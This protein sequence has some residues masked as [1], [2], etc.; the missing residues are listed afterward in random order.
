VLWLHTQSTTININFPSIYD[1]FL[2]KTDRDCINNSNLGN[3]Q[4][5]LFEA[6][7]ILDL[8]DETVSKKNNF[9]QMIHQNVIW[10]LQQTENGDFV[11]RKS[12]ELDDVCIRVDINFEKGQVIKNP[13]PDDQRVN[14]LLA[15]LDL[16]LY[17]NW[18]GKYG[19]LILHASGVVVNGVGYCFL[20]AS[21]A[22]KSTLA[23]Y[24]AQKH[25]LT[26]LGE[27]HII[28]R[29]LEGN[30]WVFG[31]PW[32]EDPTLC[33]PLGVPL[34]KLVFIDLEAKPGI[35]TINRLEGVTRVLQTAFVPYYRAD[36]T[37][38]ILE[39]LT[40]LVGDVPCFTLNYTLGSDPFDIIVKA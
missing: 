5:N 18:L 33:A 23:A 16:P 20:G 6:N 1:K 14:Y 7:L 15:S 10:K 2:I 19:D 13:A 26:V 37:N 27:D 21:G 4:R 36:L 24:L 8:T 34:E 31:S 12:F 25:G 38:R 32:H 9:G 40:K 22:G 29:C 17:V 30:F 35:Q 39:R 28:L 3:P 11:F